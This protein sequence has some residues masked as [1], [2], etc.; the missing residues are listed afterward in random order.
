MAAGI[1]ALATAAPA[2]AAGFSVQPMTFDVTVGPSDETRCKIDADLY[3]PDGASA[4]RPVPAILATNGFGGDK[5]GF[6]E[7]GRSYAERGYAFLG[8]S[9]LGFGRS[10]CK[11]YLD[12]PDWDGKAGS[13]LVSF[14]GG[15]KANAAGERIDFIVRDRVAHD[16]R[17]YADDP[18]V[19][20]LNGS[21]G[22]AIQFAV[23]SQDPRLDAI[24]PANTWNDLAYALAPN[25]AD[26]TA[27]VAS[28]TPGVTKAQWPA[29]FFAAGLL[30]LRSGDPSRAGTCP[31]YA[32]WVCGSL[33]SSLARGYADADTHARLRHASVS[34]YISKI[35]IPTLLTQGEHDTLF[36]LQE[37]VATYQALRAQDTPV[38]FIWQSAGHSGGV[39]GTAETDW[40]DPEAAYQ[41]R[42]ELEWFDWYL[43][44]V[45]D[46][47]PL[48]FSFFRDWAAYTGDA[49]PAVGSAP[50]YP[51]GTPRTFLLSGTDGLVESGSQVEPGVAQMVASPAPASTGGGVVDSGSS[52]APGTS[53][54]YTSAPLAQDTDVA[55]VPAI[56]V[57]LDAPAFAQS[58]RI[59]AAGK[60][61]LFAKL[62]DVDPVTGTSVL[63]A[64]L[65]SAARVGD[66][67]RP[68]RIELP[69][70]VHRFP[71]GHQLRL[72]LTTGSSAF[73]GNTSAGAV[74]VVV[75]PESP[76][77]L[78]LPQLGEPAGPPGSG[79]AGTTPF[80]DAGGAT[81]ADVA[82][83]GGRRAKRTRASGSSSRSVED[84][85]EPGALRFSV[86]P[87]RHHV[88]RLDQP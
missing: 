11:I 21:Y 49:A 73:K 22:G 36:N 46:P 67:S 88:H 60:L 18:R 19:G 28:S 78:S 44:G 39:L 23:A 4:A 43:K 16:G 37:A 1:V 41:S 59:D 81:V 45:G 27:G 24:S 9:G 30:G 56:T 42:I 20:M 62:Y 47:P 87:E 51:V 71:E 79:P 54:S 75:D 10:G 2:S 66:V 63:P 65:V 77:I 53:V 52:D 7:I 31:N 35:R 13:Q 12:D 6:A 61:V 38:R 74:G 84:R 14:L 29:G 80:A 25:N 72:T 83:P 32:D 17:R 68:V 3:T 76:P 58:G 40:T 50:S 33:A 8:Y 57:R 86:V 34:S 15:S 55:G 70:I 69:G 64:N 26:L 85:R 5:A 82:T 48:N